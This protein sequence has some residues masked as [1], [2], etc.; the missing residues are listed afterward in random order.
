MRYASDAYKEV[1]SRNIRNRGYVSVELGIINQDAQKNGKVTSECVYYCKKNSIFSNNI[2]EKVYASLEENFFRLDGSM[3][4]LPDDLKEVANCAISKK[5]YGNI[6]IEFDTVYD[7]KGISINFGNNYPTEFIIRSEEKE[8]YYKNS[9]SVFKTSDVIGETSYIDIIPIKMVG[10]RQRLRIYNIVMGVGLIFANEEVENISLADFVSVIGDELSSFDSTINLFDKNNLF[11]VEDD[12][13][14]IQYLDAMQK[15]VI[16]FGIELD[17]NSVEWIKYTTL[18]LSGWDSRKGKLSINAY[19]RIVS[20]EDE[21]TLGNRIY[22]RT[23][24]EE[25]ENIFKDAGLTPDEYYIDDYLQN[26]TLNNPMPNIAHRECLQLLANACRCVLIH[27]VDGRIV[28][29]ANFAN[30]LGAEEVNVFTNGE[31]P[32][33]NSKNILTGTDILYADM[34]ANFFRLDGSMYFLP[35]KTDYMKTSYVSSQV[36]NGTGLFSKIPILYPSDNIYPSDKLF[37]VD[38]K[39]G[40]FTGEN[41]PELTIT[42]PAAYPYYGIMLKFNG[43]VPN[44]LVVST[45]KNNVFLESFEVEKI[46]KI[47][48]LN[49]DF[50]PFDRLNIKFTETKPYSRIIL[51]EMALEEKA[52]YKLTRDMMLEN[53]HGYATEKIKSVSVK[54]YSF[55]NDDD[56]E[57]AEVEDSNYVK[58]TIGVVGKNI[59]LENQLIS[60]QQ[61]AKEVAKWLANYYANNI[62]YDILYRGEPLLMA[63]DLIGME[64]SINKD[65][66]AQ[67]VRSEFSFNGVFEGNLTLKKALKLV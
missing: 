49:H 37:L 6:K 41:E 13:S 34:T 32:W 40:I 16:S 38:E 11:D 35:D 33:S 7:L 8:I 2:E 57:P 56:G 67:I 26:V 3:Y 61:H 53:P 21:Y 63:S 51:N 9:E 59:V 47:F 19:D 5:I 20:L 45:Y 62:S 58:R 14:Y 42:L 39:D 25:A 60:T 17:D 65:I 23:A 55:E 36:S 24:Y 12:N 27:D 22:T 18:F 54:V 1:M 15:I 66:Q 52:S 29:K 43:N 10:G 44:K 46:Q 4:F 48:T 30:I 28:I 64:G 50:L 31:T